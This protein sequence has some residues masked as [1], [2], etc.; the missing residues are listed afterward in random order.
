MA[1]PDIRDQ[2]QWITPSIMQWITMAGEPLA[3]SDAVDCLLLPVND[4]HDVSVVNGGNHWSLMWVNLREKCI[5]HLD[6]LVGR[7]ELVAKQ[8]CSR[9]SIGS[10]KM[11]LSSFRFLQPSDIPRQENGSDCGIFV[12][13][14][15]QELLKRYA[16]GGSLSVLQQVASSSDQKA[17]TELRRQLK[18]Y[19]QAQIEKISC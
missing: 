17:A 6:S 8:I 1:S 12:L 3:V 4:N 13:L 9:V 2:V 14:Y 11:K 15:I 7:N 5:Y 18:S 19:I 10:S 16:Q